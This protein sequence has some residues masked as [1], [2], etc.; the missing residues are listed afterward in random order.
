MGDGEAWAEGDGFGEGAEVDVIVGREEGEGDG[1]GKVNISQPAPR[2]SS[3]A[4][5]RRRQ[6]FTEPPRIKAKSSAYSLILGA[7]S[8]ANKCVRLDPGREIT[9]IKDIKSDLNDSP[10]RQM[11]LAVVEAL[12]AHR[13]KDLACHDSIARVVRM[14]AVLEVFR[15]RRSGR[16][17]INLR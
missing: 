5:I 13:L 6:F 1:N 7:F 4:A 2:K 11:F 3:E 16:V 9:Y 15:M 14:H 10:R 8:R 17:L 12:V